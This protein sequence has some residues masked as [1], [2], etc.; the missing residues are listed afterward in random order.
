M[1]L[2]Y[3]WDHDEKIVRL[4]LSFPSLREASGLH[5]FEPRQFEEWVRLRIFGK[6]DIDKQALHAGRFIIQVSNGQTWRSGPFEVVTAMLVWN[7]E[8][9]SAFRAW[10]D[11][12][13][14]RPSAR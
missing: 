11:S 12:P 3:G 4:A 6:D 9:R 7:D 10:C 14:Q 5:P 8:H 2:A 1:Y 13:W